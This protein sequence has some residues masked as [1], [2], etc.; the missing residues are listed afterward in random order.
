MNKKIAL[1]VALIVSA[2][3]L[4]AILIFRPFQP[5]IPY[6][7]ADGLSM[8][9]SYFRAYD[10]IGM[11]SDFSKHLINNGTSPMDYFK[12][13][14]T[15]GDIRAVIIF[16]NYLPVTPVSITKDLQD[17]AGIQ[18]SKVTIEVFLVTDQKVECFG[19]LIRHTK[20]IHTHFV[21][22]DGHLDHGPPID[23][24]KGLRDL[25]NLPPNYHIQPLK[26]AVIVQT[27]NGLR[28]YN[29]RKD[30]IG[31]GCHTLIPYVPF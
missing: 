14:S 9:Q 4:L 20:P 18:E 28:I 25:E 7:P 11:A 29:S 26:S 15:Q 17:G 13:K 24:Q 10:Q 16:T 21:F 2:F 1:R 19:D 30:P 8:A 31:R 27:V 23:I 5:N 6:D 12:S 3:V 22:G